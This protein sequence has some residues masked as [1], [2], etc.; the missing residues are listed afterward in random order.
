[1]SSKTVSSRSDT[2]SDLIR[3]VRKIKAIRER[4]KLAETSAKKHGWVTRTPNEMLDRFKE[5]ARRDG[6]L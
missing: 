4:L 3:Q 6:E 1:M 5:N 2:Q